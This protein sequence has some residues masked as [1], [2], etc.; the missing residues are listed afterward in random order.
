MAT[1]SARSVDRTVDQMLRQMAKTSKAG[2]GSSGSSSTAAQAL[3]QMAEIQKRIARGD[4]DAAQFLIER[5]SRP[6]TAEGLAEDRREKLEALKSQAAT[7]GG[8][9]SSKNLLAAIAGGAALLLVVGVVGISSLFAGHSVAGSVM[10]DRKPLSKIE[11][12]FHPKSGDGQPIRVTTCERGTFKIG[13]LPAGEY[14]IF[15][16]PSDLD[17]KLPRKY[18]SPETTPFRLKLTKDR[19]D[20]RMLAVSEPQG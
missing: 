17:I 15:V 11:I 6:K 14:A 10:L 1:R 3:A 20:L 16:S 13:S 9:G 5:A 8:L 4:T 18:L 2:A 7:N 19:S 12:A